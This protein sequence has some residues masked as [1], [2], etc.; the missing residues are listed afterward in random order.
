MS[1]FE[2]F[3]KIYDFLCPIFDIGIMT[4]ILYKAYELIVKTNAMQIIKAGIIVAIAFVVA[5]IFQLSMLKWALNFLAPGLVICFAIVFQPE[6]R[7][8]F[9]KLG[10]KD[11]FT[12]G[13]RAKHSS[14]DSVLIAADM[15]SKQKRGMLTVFMR[16]TKVDD[17][18]DTGT[19][20]NADLSSNLLVTIFGHNTPLHDGACFIQGG[21]IV[22]AGCF[23][24]LSEQYD[25]KKTF[26]T[27]HRAALGLCETTDCVVLIVSEETGALSLAYD[28]KLHYD[29]KSDQIIKI[30]ENLLHLSKEDSYVEDI[31]DE[32][33]PLIK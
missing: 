9:L 26:G 27:R 28:S 21:K 3:L 17:I 23:L 14:I 5:T 25:I 31:I 20:I 30:L 1:T 32:R 24:P 12:F 16:N 4:F 6:L 33:Q 2:T 10:Q 18:L 15:L 22:S 11:W 29:L 8:I 13:N 7:K 19:R